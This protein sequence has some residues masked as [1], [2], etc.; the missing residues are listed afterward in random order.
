MMKATCPL[1][2]GP[3]SIVALLPPTCSKSRAPGS[4]GPFEPNSASSTTARR[5]PRAAPTAAML[6]SAYRLSVSGHQRPPADTR[7]GSFC[8]RRRARV[9]LPCAHLLCHL[10]Q[11]PAG[12]GFG[13]GVF[14]SGDQTQPSRSVQAA[15]CLSYARR[16]CL[17]ETE[18]TRS[19]PPTCFS[20]LACSVIT[21][22]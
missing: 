13:H 22:F 17:R 16:S 19:H 6:E 5:E 9:S 10:L 20:R 7:L 12:E 1:G 3:L 15:R 2:Q 4:S 18:A 21:D 11:D 14:S 8:R